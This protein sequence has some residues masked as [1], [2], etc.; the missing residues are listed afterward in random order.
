MIVL[1]KG[2]CSG[3]V[4]MAA[5]MMSEDL[6]ST[7]NGLGPGNSYAGHAVGA[8]VASAHMDIIE[9]ENLLDNAN[10]RGAQFLEELSPLLDHPF[11]GDIR[12]RGLMMGIEL[13][14][15]KETR[16]PLVKDA[17]WLFADLPRYMRRAHGI[18]LGLRANVIVVTPP[19]VITSE[20]VSQI[21]Q[22]LTQTM[23]RIDQKSLRLPD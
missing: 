6:A 18:L 19:L 8:A 15:D 23:A 1:A 7:V 3:Y 5:V 9:H 21:C 20:D 13:V 11:V 4:P 12:G 14:S 22:A 16:A 10:A 2:M 17:P